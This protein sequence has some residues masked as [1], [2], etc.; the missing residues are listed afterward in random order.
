VQKGAPEDFAAIRRQMERLQQEQIQEGRHRQTSRRKSVG[1]LPVERLFVD[2]EA[3][4]E[5]LSEYAADEGAHLILIAGHGGFGKT[6]LAAKFCDGIEKAKYQLCS[7]E[8]VLPI[9]GVVYVSK[10]EMLSFSADRLFDKL[11]QILE[12]EEISH[13]QP[14][15]RDPQLPVA[16]KTERLLDAL[17]GD[18]MLLILDNFEVMLEENRITHPDLEIFLQTVCAV[19]HSL[20]LIITS[21][22]DIRVDDLGVRRDIALNDGL[23]TGHA[24]AFLR[25]LGAGT[26]Q[27]EGTED[28][29]LKELAQKVYGVPMALRSLASFLKTN[30]RLGIETLLEDE[31]RFEDFRRHDYKT[32]LRKLIQE[33]YNI[34][35]DEARLA[36]QVLAVFNAPVRPVAVQYLLPKLDAEAVLDALA[37]NYFL[38]QE[39]QDLFELHP[40]VQ[41][42]AYEQIPVESE[43]GEENDP[44]TRTALHTRAADFFAELKKPES[45]WKSLPDL[46]PHLDE[47]EQRMRAGQFDRAAMVLLD[48]DFDYLLVWGHYRLMAE[49]HEGLQGKIDDP[50]LKRR[51][52]GNM[53]TA[54]LNM[55]Q[56]DR[57]I[58]CYEQALENARKR[59]DRRGE[60]A[61]LGNLGSCYYA[62]GELPCAIEFYEQAL[63]IDREIGYRRGEAIQLGNLGLCH[64]ALG[65]PARAIE[66]HEQALVI[67]RE[68]GSRQGEAADLGSLGSCYSNLGEPA[69]AIEYHEQALVI[70][71]EIG[72]RQGEAADLAGLGTCYSDLG[73]PARAIEYH[74]QALVI[75]REIGHHRGEAIQLGNL[76]LCY[77]NLGEPARAIE[78]HEQA[79][80]IAREIGYRQGEAIQLENLGHVFTD[81]SEWDKALESYRQA[82]QIADEIGFPQVQNWGRWGMSLARLYSGDLPQARTVIEQA[83]KY[84]CPPN[85]PNVMT[86][87]GIIALRQRDSD[88][89][90]EAFTAA[91]KEADALLIHSD[92]NFSALDARALSLWGMA[93]C[94][95]NPV[96]IRD[97]AAAFRAAREITDA[98]GT[99]A[100]VMRLFEELAKADSEGVLENKAPE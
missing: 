44:F 25:K 11:M 36:L 94:E 33:Q 47:I 79:L 8:T 86:L 21:R 61:W 87:L 5:R 51:S 84:S 69:R 91:I 46:Q 77:A 1:T 15:I 62:I 82:I 63:V 89:A 3:Y 70:A 9:R 13:L 45:E 65:E 96:H 14:I 99:V 41:E 56:K 54:Y 23:E 2:R 98:P 100:H 58:Q 17:R 37:F 34:L 4:L 42:L 93:L 6:A 7:G 22:Y 12:P 20:K 49:L 28:E 55:G 43:S 76:G 85:M 19:R 74:E 97:G 66:Y 16:L 83:Q 24:V 72:H 92:R 71:R 57:A 10:T 95:Q 81:Q 59:E 48:I 26:R 31:T 30:R 52:V 35:P 73:E 39:N 60:G 50:E 38:A 40:A 64:A 53:G 88:T 32:G 78:Y 80:V 68:I 75:D 18:P 29:Q 90:K 27:I 67:D